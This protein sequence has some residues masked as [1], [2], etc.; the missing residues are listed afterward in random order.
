MFSLTLKIT[1]WM[2]NRILFCGTRTHQLLFSTEGSGCR[3]VKGIGTE[4]YTTVMINGEERDLAEILA[5]L[6][7][8]AF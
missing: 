7:R 1:G 6:G 4:K 8:K 2:V 3:S 5:E